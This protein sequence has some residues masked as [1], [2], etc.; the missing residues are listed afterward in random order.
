MTKQDLGTAGAVSLA[1]FLRRNKSVEVLDLT[2]A[3][4][5]GD[6]SS[7]AAGEY[8]DR[9]IEALAVAFGVNSKLKSVKMFGNCIRDDSVKHLTKA[10]LA[11]DSITSLN[12]GYNDF[13][14]EG[15]KALAQAAAGN[16]TLLELAVGAGK[17]RVQE[18]KGGVQSKRK[19][20][21]LNLKNQTLGPL[22]A[23]VVAQLLKANKTATSIDL[24]HNSLRKEGT[25]ALCEVMEGM[26]QLA[27]INISS[28]EIY[29][30]GGE[31]MA[32]LVEKCAKLS[33][34]KVAE[35]NLTNWGQSCAPLESIV[36]NALRTDT[37]KVLHL[38]GNVLREPG[39]A[40]IAR[41]IKESKTLEEIDL[42]RAQL[43]PDGAISIA[44]A[45]T[46][47]ESN[48]KVLKLGENSI[49]SRGSTPLVEALCTSG[50]TLAR[51][52][53]RK[54]NIPEGCVLGWIDLLLHHR[55]EWTVEEIDLSGNRIS[56]SLI[57][58]FSELP[59]RAA[60]RYGIVT[61]A[62]RMAP[63]KKFRD[64][65][66][67]Q[68]SG[69]FEDAGGK[70]G[71]EEEEAVESEGED[72]GTPI[73]R[74]GVP[75]DAPSKSD[76]AV[77]EK[78]VSTAAKEWVSDS[79]KSPTGPATSPSPTFENDE[80][81]FYSSDDDDMDPATL[82]AMREAYNV[83]GGGGD[84]GKEGPGT[85]VKLGVL[86]NAAGEAASATSSSGASHAEVIQAMG[87][88]TGTGSRPLVQGLSPRRNR[89][90]SS[91][92][93]SAGS[94]GTVNMKRPAAPSSPRVVGPPS[95]PKPDHLG[96]R[97]S[98]L[99]VNDD[100][101]MKPPP[102]RMKARKT[103]AELKKLREEQEADY[104]RQEDV[105][106]SYEIYKQQKAARDAAKNK[107]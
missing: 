44:D 1:E 79:L 82:A 65:Y 34:L 102:K 104:K 99:K 27:E 10:I 56:S 107:K 17:I 80:E 45:L 84:D 20:G 26:F 23:L 86:N 25:R 50:H 63:L 106:R 76:D 52:D 2:Q 15:V 91:S 42:S 97:M 32:A 37:L 51:L 46:G 6:G 72:A 54:N 78:T 58:D 61:G 68:K 71:A 12:L 14:V 31:S 66:E 47:K 64:N 55:D 35:N 53:L 49:G 8:D 7:G 69:I 40:A 29:P 30:D 13:T 89:S 85:G 92:R 77:V 43:G 38:Q 21:H 90:K 96:G 59:K 73:S 9:G 70:H 98:L 100:E 4:L 67:A 62:S 95:V 75:M 57:D 93:G 81:E 101:G 39:A 24:S 5:T 74:E 3:T 83:M 33:V 16:D 103:A 41:L 60:N 28:N 87:A 22:S 105:A 94:G 18:V 19:P 36:A 48:L 88:S 11:N